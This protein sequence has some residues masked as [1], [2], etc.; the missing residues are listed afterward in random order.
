V[1]L[2]DENEVVARGPFPHLDVRA[3]G[4]GASC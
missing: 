1:P 4:Q 3:L 2:L